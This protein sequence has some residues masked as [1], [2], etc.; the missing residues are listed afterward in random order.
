VKAI[1]EDGTAREL[2][3]DAGNGEVLAMEQEDEGIED[4]DD[5]EE[6]ERE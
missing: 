4:E 6:N 2:Y 1:A 3:I 5:R